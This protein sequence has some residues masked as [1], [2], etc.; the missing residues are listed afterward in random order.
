MI[1]IYRVENGKLMERWV[2]TDL[3]GLIE[4]LDIEQVRKRGLPPLSPSPTAGASPSS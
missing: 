3:H 2:A 1:A 4:D